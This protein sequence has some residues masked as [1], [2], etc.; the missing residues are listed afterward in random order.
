MTDSASLKQIICEAFCDVEYPG[1]EYL[2]GSNEGEEPY[3]L[4]DEF[5]GR[6][7]WKTLDAAFLDQ[8]PDGYASALS[9]FS[10]E[11]FRFYL[12]AYLIADLDQQLRIVDP[13]FHL[14]FGLDDIHGPQPINPRRYGDRTWW[15]EKQRKFALFS[16]VQAAAIAA[17]LKYKSTQDEFQ[18]PMIEQA[19]QN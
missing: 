9:F 13:T 12:P 6:N 14:C 19:L 5:K 18:R 3:L 10:D 17:Y 15:T 8:A 1:D 7:D 4:E 11:A 16:P 2:K